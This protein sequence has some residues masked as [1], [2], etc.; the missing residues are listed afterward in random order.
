MGT[1]GE[2]TPSAAQGGSS[3]RPRPSVTSPQDTVDKIRIH[4]VH[5]GAPAL[6]K[7]RVMVGAQGLFG[8]LHKH[9]RDRLPL[10]PSKPQ[11]L[12]LYV[13]SSFSPGPD[14]RIID[15]YRCFGARGEL[16]INYCLQHSYG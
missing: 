16:T 2:G 12:F 1:A 5:Q 8:T 6:A 11:P 13:D 15:L 10:D 3:G 14:E 7:P 4:F 9:L